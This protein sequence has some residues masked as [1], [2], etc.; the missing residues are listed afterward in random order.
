MINKKEKLATYLGRD[1]NFLRPAYEI[2]ADRFI[3]HCPHVAC[4]EAFFASLSAFPRQCSL[5]FPPFSCSPCVFS[6]P[7]TCILHGLVVMLLFNFFPS[8]NLGLTVLHDIIS[9]VYVCAYVTGLHYLPGGG[10]CDR[11]ENRPCSLH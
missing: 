5:F 11:S 8:L 9:F 1:L 2:R 7:C 10:R 6:L 4:A 3:A